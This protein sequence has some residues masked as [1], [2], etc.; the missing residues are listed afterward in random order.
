[1]LE[2]LQRLKPARHDTRIAADVAKLAA[3][4]REVRTLE[5]L[6][7]YISTLDDDE[8]AHAWPRLIEAIYSSPQKCQISGLGRTSAHGKQQPSSTRA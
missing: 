8:L 6:I 3:R 1:M 4:E 7:E 2:L 5:M